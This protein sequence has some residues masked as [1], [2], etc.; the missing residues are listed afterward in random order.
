MVG[1]NATLKSSLHSILGVL[2]NANTF[3][4]DVYVCMDVLENH[5]GNADVKIPWL[6]LPTLRISQF[7]GINQHL[8]RY[9]SLIRSGKRSRNE[10]KSCNSSSKDI[11]KYKFSVTDLYA[12][13][14]RPS[15]HPSIFSSAYPTQGY[16]GFGVKS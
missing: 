4:S 14:V 6:C 3:L 2:M 5:H 1:A 11:F 7:H 10:I 9:L 13:A 15:I 12:V 16:R 8:T